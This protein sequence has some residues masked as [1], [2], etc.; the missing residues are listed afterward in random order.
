MRADHRLARHRA[1]GAGGARAGGLSAV[2]VLC[3]RARRPRSD[4]A[5]AHPIAHAPRAAAARVARDHA[6]AAA[7]V[8]GA[9]VRTRRGLGRAHPALTVERAAEQLVVRTRRARHGEARAVGVGGARA[10]VRSGIARGRGLRTGVDGALCAVSAGSV[11]AAWTSRGARCAA[12]R[13]RRGR[14]RQVSL[15]R[16]V[17]AGRA[18]QQRDRGP[19]PQETCEAKHGSF[20]SE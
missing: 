17:A 14:G 9:R 13:P 4:H 8:V 2:C 1:V 18:D 16:L 6:R 20:A 12:S 3:A 10:G 7:C 11:V 5:M 15:R 19:A